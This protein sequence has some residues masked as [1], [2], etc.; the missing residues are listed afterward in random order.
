MSDQISDEARRDVT[1]ALVNAGG[2][3]VG[4]LVDTDNSS[5]LRREVARKRREEE[6]RRKKE[7]EESPRFVL[8]PFSAPRTLSLFWDADGSRL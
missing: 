2:A 7:E 1:D 4:Q 5:K 6:E 3:A 8:A